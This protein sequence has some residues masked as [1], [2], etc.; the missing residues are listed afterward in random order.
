[1]K[2]S[3]DDL[4]AMDIYD[5]IATCLKYHNPDSMVEFW[6]LSRM[7]AV[8]LHSIAISKAFASTIMDFGME[9]NDSAIVHLLQLEL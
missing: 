4:K 2:E 7:V 1:M 9:G 8:K 5:L 6:Q 3:I